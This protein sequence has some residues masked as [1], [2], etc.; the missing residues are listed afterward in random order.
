MNPLQKLVDLFKQKETK[1]PTASG[2]VQEMPQATPV[3]TTTQKPP[4]EASKAPAKPFLDVLAFIESSNNPKAKA[5][6]SSAA[7]LYQY[8]EATWNDFTK[9][10]GKNYT[11]DDRFD[12][13]K[14]REVAEFHVKQNIDL[15]KG[16]LDR[17]PTYTEKYM[18]HFLGRSGVQRFLKADPMATVD[19]VAT[20]AQLKANRSIFFDKGGKPKRVAE[21]YDFFKGKIDAA[22]KME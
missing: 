9:K 17:E 12:P 14:A 11:L 2:K 16:V 6:T 3:P 20:P 21:V 18:A 1:N 15:L 10:M 8:T 4:T 13:K 7:G 19:K 5:P 22:N